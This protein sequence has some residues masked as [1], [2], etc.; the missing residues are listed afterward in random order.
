MCS[1][2]CVLNVIFNYF[3]PTIYCS[4][5]IRT[6]FS[7]FNICKGTGKA[8]PVLQAHRPGQALRIPEG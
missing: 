4:Y 2:N 1:R 7:Y 5:F 6:E 3:L 8:I